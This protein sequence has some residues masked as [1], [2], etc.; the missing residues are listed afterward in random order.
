MSLED[1]SICITSEKAFKLISHN[2]DITEN[3]N[4]IDYVIERYKELPPIKYLH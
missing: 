4:K 1:K 2:A 3:S